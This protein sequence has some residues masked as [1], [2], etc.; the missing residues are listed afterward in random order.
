MGK[1]GHGG[2]VL[3]SHHL[4]VLTDVIKAEGR[5]TPISRLRHRKTAPKDLGPAN[6]RKSTIKVSPCDHCA[7]NDAAVRAKA[8]RGKARSFSPGE[9]IE[10]C[11]K[12]V[13]SYEKQAAPGETP[14]AYAEVFLPLYNVVHPYDIVLIKQVLFGYCRYHWL[15]NSFIKHFYT[16]KA[17]MLSQG[18]SLLY[19]VLVY[20]AVFR[21]DEL[22]WREFRRLCSSQIPVKILP[23]VQAIFLEELTIRYSKDDWLKIYDCMFVNDL[24]R[25]LG[26][27]REE[28]QVYTEKLAEAVYGPDPGLRYIPPPT[29]IIPFTLSI[30]NYT[31]IVEEPEPY[32]YKAKPAPLWDKGRTLEMKRVSQV[33]KLNRTLLKEKYSDPRY[34]PFRIRS[35][36]RPTNLE[37]IR[38][39]VGLNR[40]TLAGI[41][42]L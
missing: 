21:L 15:I 9:L 27:F 28:A 30:S 13:G 32:I 18:D 6:W 23:F 22:N 24:L 39:E 41:M 11:T 40:V 1:T 34:Q 29:T 37:T 35:L 17:T 12:I 42:Y 25:G 16:V 14:D 7:A 38:E 20:L 10:A 36:E 26:L 19:K 31:H 2:Y 5:Y 8:W 33:F 4:P 3:C